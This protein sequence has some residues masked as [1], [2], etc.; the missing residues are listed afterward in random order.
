MFVLC[1]I[2][3]ACSTYF[4]AIINIINPALVFWVQMDPAA[5]C[6]DRLGYRDRAIFMAAEDKQ[7]FG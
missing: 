1:C 7:F 3:L 4:N 5:D 2:Y 6:G